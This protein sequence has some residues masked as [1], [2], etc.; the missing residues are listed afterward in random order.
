MNQIENINHSSWKDRTVQAWSRCAAVAGA[1]SASVICGTVNVFATDTTGEIESAVSSGLENAWTLLRA[2]GIP[3]AIVAV[4][5]CAFQ[6]FLNGDKGM[7][8][9]KKRILYIILGI[10]ILLLAPLLVTKVVGWFSSNSSWST[11]AFG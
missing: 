1:V 8:T 6:F 3:V 4:A 11:V 9:A 5:I 2:I 10:A 7:E